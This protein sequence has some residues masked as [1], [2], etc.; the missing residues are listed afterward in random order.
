MAKVA[1]RVATG[2]RLEGH[3][4]GRRGIPGLFRRQTRLKQ[5]QIQGT[6]EAIPPVSLQSQAGLSFPT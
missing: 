6:A 2:K 5:E 4:A 3:R 1:P